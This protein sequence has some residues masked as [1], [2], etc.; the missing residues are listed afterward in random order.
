MVV[1]SF[2]FQ[3]DPAYFTQVIFVH[4]RVPFISNKNVLGS[5]NVRTL[6]KLMVQLENIKQEVNRLN[7]IF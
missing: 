2:I 1:F 6:N 5:W 4:S 3:F 7:N